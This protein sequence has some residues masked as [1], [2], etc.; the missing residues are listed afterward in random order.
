M[1]DVEGD[2]VLPPHDAVARIT[3]TPRPAYNPERLIFRDLLQML[4]PKVYYR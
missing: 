1:D 4:W 3:A 2:A